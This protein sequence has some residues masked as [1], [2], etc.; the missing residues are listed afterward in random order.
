[1]NFLNLKKINNLKNIS[2]FFFIFSS[3]FL[4]G[5]N[6]VFIQYLILL[7]IFFLLLKNSKIYL[8]KKNFFLIQIIIILLFHYIVFTLYN[9]LDF[10]FSNIVKLGYTF[11]IFFFCVNFYLVFLK[12]VKK[13][14]IF[15]VF[16]SLTLLIFN[17]LL[18]VYSLD[19]VNY[20]IDFNQGYFCSAAIKSFFRN[21]FLFAEASHLSM[22]NAAVCLSCIYYLSLE[23]NFLLKIL[24][25]AHLVISLFSG[26]TTFLVG[27]F[28]SSITIFIFCNKKLNLKFV[29][30]TIFFNFII[31]ISFFSDKS[32]Y[33]RILEL[34]KNYQVQ[35][36]LINNY[37]NQNNLIGE[38]EKNQNLYFDELYIR[39]HA[40]YSEFFEISS[41]KKREDN[42]N[43]KLIEL[44][45]KILANEKILKEMNFLLF[46]TRNEFIALNLTNQVY[47]RSLFIAK[48]S[49]L[50]SYF[51]YGFENYKQ[52]FEI[53]K[54][55][56][57]AINPIVLSLNV[58]DASNNFSKIIVEFGF[59][60]IFIFIILF[61]S[62]L[63]NTIKPE[64]KIFL[65]SII[66]TQ[67]I[68]GAGYYNGGFLISITFLSLMNFVKK[69]I[70]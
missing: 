23:K 22:V 6:K 17:I 25:T 60:S 50:D 16:L 64:I 4:W 52:A 32:C 57:P 13:L 2:A 28:F 46:K 5:L 30:L 10:N 45:N 69:K 66:L 51:G 68:R 8:K 7:P 18:S 1:M 48:N 42:E 43:L 61:I 38:N 63:N 29:L 67:F 70:S 24:F 3:Y 31:L 39:T 56:V 65:L 40:L 59:L 53:Y 9:N 14:I 11:L 21:N 49:L 34:E 37:F 26:A 41:K 27:F 55:V 44:K 20:K 12:N 35:N 33:T 19:F 36:N 54:F 58:Y 62:A 15:F 47:I